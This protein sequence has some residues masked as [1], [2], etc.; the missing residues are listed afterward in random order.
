MIHLAPE[1]RILMLKVEN[2]GKSIICLGGRTVGL[3][4]A[5]WPDRANQQKV[6]IC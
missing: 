5:Q 1:A 6:S 2:G 4:A 3:V